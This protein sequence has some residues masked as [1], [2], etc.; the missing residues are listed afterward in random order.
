MHL[1]HRCCPCHLLPS[2][3]RGSPRLHSVQSEKTGYSVY[4]ENLPSLSLMTLRFFD[5]VAVALER[6]TISRLSPLLGGSKE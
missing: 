1:R 5:F 4:E 2:I 6:L 3:F